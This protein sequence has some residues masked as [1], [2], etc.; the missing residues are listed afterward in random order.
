MSADTMVMTSFGDAVGHFKRVI[1]KCAAAAPKYRRSSAAAASLVTLTD[2]VIEENRT[3]TPAC[4]KGCA[5]CCHVQTD[6]FA[7]EAFVLAAAL[8]RLPSEQRADIEGRLRS[9]ARQVAPMTL[10]ERQRARIPC[11]F[12]DRERRACSV[13]EDR[14]SACRRWHSLDADVCRQDFENPSVSSPLDANAFRAAQ[15]VNVAYKQARAE[16]DGELHAGVLMA[17]ADDAEK[18]FM[19]G[20]PVFDGWH[21]TAEIMSEEERSRM[22]QE[23]AD[24]WDIHT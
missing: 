10:T 24:I 6:I 1:R 4:A 12:L 2:R 3:A 5:W 16:P 15:T 9:N 18:R 14:P 17:L 22:R 11:A 19:K 7:G 8:R 23:M 20:A 21:S 13:Y